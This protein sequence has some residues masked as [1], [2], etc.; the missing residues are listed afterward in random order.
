[1]WIYCPRCE[2]KQPTINFIYKDENPKK[3]PIIKCSLCSNEFG[4]G[5]ALE[6]EWDIMIKS[7]MDK[8]PR[9]FFKE[10]LD[11]LEVIKMPDWIPLQYKSDVQFGDG[12][13]V[14]FFKKWNLFEYFNIENVHTVKHT[15]LYEISGSPIFKEIFRLY[16]GLNIHDENAS[17]IVERDTK[18]DDMIS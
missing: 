8:F 16:F 4:Q 12:L 15:K 17:K 3:E 6:F 11:I 9:K 14:E 10:Y 5:E 7:Q 18:I 1:M 13:T 2:V